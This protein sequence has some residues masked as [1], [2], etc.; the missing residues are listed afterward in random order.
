MSATSLRADGVEQP[1][2]AAIPFTK[3]WVLGRELEYVAEA[4]RTGAIAG[5][6]PF[7]RRCARLLEERFGI[8][9]VL[10]TPSCTAALELAAQL[11]DLRPGD[12][13]IV[14]S[15]TFVTTASSFVRLGARPVFVEI[16]PDTLNIDPGRIEDAV[17][18]RTRAIFP[19][20]YAGVG[21]DMDEI[22]E[23][24]RRHR[25][26]VVEDAAQGVN[27]FY[28]GRAL[29]SMGDLGAYSFHHTKNLVCGE[30]G[31]LCVNDPGLIERAEILRDKGTDRTKFLRGQVEKYTWV[32][33]GS[34]SIPSEITCAFLAAQLEAMD[35]ITARRREIDRHYRHRLAPLEAAGLLRLPVVPP[36]CESHC[37]AFHILLE[38]A[39]VRDGLMAFLKRHGVSAVFHFVPL[40]VSP[41]GRQ[42]GYRPGDLPLTE[43]L[44][45][46]ILRLPSFGTITAAQQDRVADLITAYLGGVGAR[47]AVAYSFS[48]VV[49]ACQ[50]VEV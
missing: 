31:A 19:I 40:H 16:R 14:P 13:V 27:A 38:G 33:V 45:G 43:D 12:E 17:T 25:L 9:K 24:A 44:A 11:C 36:Q 32:D 30:G 48:A 39:G 35:T 15:Y 18:R 6:G 8:R 3:P 50:E 26:R 42:F 46:R 47:G 21:C 7:T 28:K 20:D 23:I 22:L 29:G 34:S 37:R 49:A 10:M 5:D 1:V 41:M 4:V 2:S